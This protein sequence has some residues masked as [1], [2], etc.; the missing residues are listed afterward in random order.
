MPR[1]PHDYTDLFLAPVALAVDQRLEELGGLDPA[2]LQRRI[3]LE[4]N[5]Y[6][7]HAAD[8][9]NAVAASATYLLDLHGWTASWDDRGVR[10][11]HDS[12][13]LVLGVPPN[14]AAYVAGPTS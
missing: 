12:H 4:S 6:T 11:S 3:A 1:A 13:G 10:L 5:Q 8:R 14:V 2:E 7:R 9:G